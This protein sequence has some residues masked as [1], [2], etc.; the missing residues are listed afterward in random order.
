M[1]GWMDITSIR[2]ESRD[3]R[4]THL[5]GLRRKQSFRTMR[6]DAMD[7]R[8][9]M[10]YKS[11]SSKIAPRVGAQRGGRS[12]SPCCM[13]CHQSANAKSSRRLHWRPLTTSTKS[14]H[15]PNSLSSRSKASKAQA[16]AVFGG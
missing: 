8:V 2:D 1:R 6:Y 11:S 3:D 9:W 4:L 7:K 5:F 16:Y 14:R 12:S 15:A 13:S 10:V